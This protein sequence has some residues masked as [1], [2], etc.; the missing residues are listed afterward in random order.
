MRM[1]DG[2]TDRNF[3]NRQAIEPVLERRTGNSESI[4]SF[5]QDRS[6]FSCRHFFV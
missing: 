6:H 3:S 2:D 5:S 1:C 4:T